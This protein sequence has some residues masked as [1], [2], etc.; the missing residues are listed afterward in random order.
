[1]NSAVDETVGESVLLTLNRYRISGLS[2]PDSDKGCGYRNESIAIKEPIYWKKY[3]SLFRNF[4]QDF[5]FTLI[6]RRRMYLLALGGLIRL[7]QTFT[8]RKEGKKML[9]P[10]RKFSPALIQHM[11]SYRRQPSFANF[12]LERRGRSICST[13]AHTS[14]AI[15]VTI[16]MYF[17]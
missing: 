6:S 13:P 11:P 8:S 15:F 2:R 14:P 12:I 5:S 17:R 10:K 9:L 16:T 4:F 7:M 3:R 1:M